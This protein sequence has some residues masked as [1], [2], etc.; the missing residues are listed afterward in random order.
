MYRELY[1]VVSTWACL[2]SA[3]VA[4]VNWF[5]SKVLSSEKE[6]EH[7]AAFVLGFEWN[8]N[9]SGDSCQF[10]DESPPSLY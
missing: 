10:D 6:I 1:N 3:V 7:C 9:I 8:K 2:L 4:D 5:R